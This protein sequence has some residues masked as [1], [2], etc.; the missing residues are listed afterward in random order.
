M[1]LF[2]IKEQGTWMTEV[3][4]KDLAL[5]TEQK[6]LLGSTKE[7]DKVAKAEVVALWKTIKQVPATTEEVAILTP[8]IN[9]KLPEAKE[10]ETITLINALVFFKDDKIE[11]G[12]ISFKINEDKVQHA[13]F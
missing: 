9:A 8:F 7:E 12:H 4:Y 3:P 11:K 6:I 1:K 5:T 2:T 10:G 13:N